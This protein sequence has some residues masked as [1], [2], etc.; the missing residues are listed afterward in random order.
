VIIFYLILL[1][2]NTLGQNAPDTLWTKTYDDGVGYCMIETSDSGYVAVGSN[3]DSLGNIDL[4][5]IKINSLGDSLWSKT[6]GD[7]G[8]DIGTSVKQTSESG[9]IILGSTSSYGSGKDD[10]WLI[11]TDV[12][13]DTIWTKTYGGDRSDVGNCIQITHDGG[14][15]IVGT[16]D[17]YAAGGEDAWLIKTDSNGDTSWTKSYTL[18]IWSGE[19]LKSSIETNDGYIFAGSDFMSGFIIKT[20]FL[21]DTLWTKLYEGEC[22]QPSPINRYPNSSPQHP[23]KSYPTQP[24]KPHINKEFKLI[25]SIIL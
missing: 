18:G 9:F 16:T 12:N 7:T 1:W 10:V 3:E 15:I 17:S 2:V 24:S 22:C 4:R 8:Y 13:G 23:H 19:W 14:Y 20:D 6:L 21:G 25:N 11:K 5:L